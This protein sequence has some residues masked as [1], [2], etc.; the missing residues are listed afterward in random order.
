M[1]LE[2]NV[3]NDNDEIVK[4]CTAQAV[5]FKFGTIRSLMKLLNVDNIDD[6]TELLKVVYGAWDQITKILSQCFPDITDEDWDNV[7]VGELIPVVVNILKISFAQI[8]SIPQ[9]NDPKNQ[10]AE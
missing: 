5:D 2:L 6:T 3:Y 7:K 8:L 1:Q 9:D 10:I 4:T